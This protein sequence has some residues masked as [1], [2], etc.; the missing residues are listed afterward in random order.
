MCAG[1]FN[2]SFVPNIRA[3]SPGLKFTNTGNLTTAQTLKEFDLPL[4]AGS[5]MHVSA[6][7]LILNIPSNLVKVTGVKVPGSSLPATYNV[8]GNELRIGWNSATAVSVSE[9][10]DL[11][12]LNLIPTAS[13]PGV[14]T[15]RLGMV[16]NY[17]N[18]VADGGFNP[19]TFA[20]LMADDVE[21][22]PQGTP[23]PV[24]L[25]AN[26]NPGTVSTTVTYQIPVAGTVNLGIYNVLGNN[27]R[28]L[29]PNHNLAAGEYSVN[30]DV[31]SLQRGI[32]YAKLTLKSG[33]GYM[34]KAIRF[35]KK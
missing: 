5:H 11:V 4:K 30:V 29:V 32:Y 1:D 16:N 23:D 34:V 10:G 20:E 8:T 2:S 18:E 35:I 27:V 7:S 14:Q 9:G 6:I 15:L 12:I 24:V 25:A 28:I 31:S 33:S 26:P 17:L 19:I 3:G 21:V 13:V 22:T